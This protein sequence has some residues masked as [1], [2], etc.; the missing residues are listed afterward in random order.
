[1]M[2]I[3]SGQFRFQVTGTSGPDYVTEASTN[4]GTWVGLGTNLAPTLPFEFTDPTAG[5]FSNRVD[6]VRLQP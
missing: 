5:A 6:R 2:K 3:A 4:F 1:M